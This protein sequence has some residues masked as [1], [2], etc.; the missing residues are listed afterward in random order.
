MEEKEIH[1]LCQRPGE[2]AQVIQRLQRVNQ[3]MTALQEEKPL[4]IQQNL[5]D[6]YKNVPGWLRKTNMI[7]LRTLQH[8]QKRC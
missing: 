1:H 4:V 8:P 7:R 2:K 6:S 3:L 5:Q